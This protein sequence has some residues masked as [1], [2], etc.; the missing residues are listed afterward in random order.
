MKIT[1]VVLA[2]YLIAGVYYVLGDIRQP[3]WKQPAYVRS[4]S[5]PA[6]LLRVII[7]PLTVSMLIFGGYRGSQRRNGIISFALFAA[8]L[9][10]GLILF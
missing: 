6:I 1:L 2:A 7:W 4:R 9:W 3:F 5:L 8:V 10:I